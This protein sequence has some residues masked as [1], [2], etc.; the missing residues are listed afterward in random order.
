[1]RFNEFNDARTDE[2]LGAVVR[3]GVEVG[4]KA[5]KTAKAQSRPE[6]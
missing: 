2:N 3:G 6:Q 4:K 1:M 5:L